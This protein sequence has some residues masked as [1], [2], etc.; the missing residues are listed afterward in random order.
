MTSRPV[1]AIAAALILAACGDDAAVDGGLSG[2]WKNSSGSLSFD[3]GNVVRKAGRVTQKGRY[4]LHDVKD[5]AGRIVIVMDGQ[6]L[7]CR[8]SIMG[9][10]LTLAEP[11]AANFDGGSFTRS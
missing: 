9:E 7:T 6:K 11:C 4:K 5:K 10:M 8:F 2:S 3:D 1:L